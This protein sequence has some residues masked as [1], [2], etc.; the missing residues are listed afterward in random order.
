[1]SSEDFAARAGGAEVVG[2]G[3][4]GTSGRAIQTA[5][6]PIVGV[7][8]DALDGLGQVG[9]G[10]VEAAQQP[11]HVAQVV[12]SRGVRHGVTEMLNAEQDHVCRS[13]SLVRSEGRLCQR[14]LK[15]EQVATVEN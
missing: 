11:D 14:R 7:S 15:T 4:E 1:M 6:R 12:D 2:E 13:D 10:K 3:V 8:G 5:D 9:D